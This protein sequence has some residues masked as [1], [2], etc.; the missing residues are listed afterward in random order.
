MAEALKLSNST[1]SAS[2]TPSTSAPPSSDQAFLNSVLQSLPGTFI[3]IIHF[4]DFWFYS[5]L[6][7][8]TN[9]FLGVDMNDERIRNV[10]SSIQTEKKDEK[11]D[12]KKDEKK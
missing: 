3:I 10:L 6:V 1:P 9:R 2:T 7:I 8:V 5:S 11:G 4:R 12:E